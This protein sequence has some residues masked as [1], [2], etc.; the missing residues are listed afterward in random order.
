MG[1]IRLNRLTVSGAGFHTGHM[2]ARHK[3]AAKKPALGGVADL[4]RRVPLYL[5]NIPRKVPVTHI[6]T[7]LSTAGISRERYFE[8]SEQAK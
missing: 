3:M 1:T 7:N 2:M 6:C 4:H 8:L 5:H